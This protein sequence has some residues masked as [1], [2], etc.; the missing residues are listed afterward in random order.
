MEDWTDREYRARELSKLGKI[1]GHA[2]VRVKLYSDE[3]ETRWL[4]VDAETYRR[5][6]NVLTSG[7]N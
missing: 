7:N 2:A 1:D 3:G 5:L 4:T 6:V